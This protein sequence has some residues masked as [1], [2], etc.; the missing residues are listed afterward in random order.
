MNCFWVLFQMNFSIDCGYQKKLQ[1]TVDDNYFSIVWIKKTGKV[2]KTKDI[3]RKIEGKRKFREL[4]LQNNRPIKDLGLNR[5]KQWTHS[6][7][8]LS[9]AIKTVVIAFD[10]KLFSAH[11]WRKWNSSNASI[12]KS[13][14]WEL[15]SWKQVKKYFGLFFSSIFPWLILL[16]FFFV[17]ICWIK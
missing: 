8:S 12:F 13:G 17:T 3:K 7:N 1:M 2:C 5:V 4:T 9:W 16:F 14:S 10:R 15:V 6:D 11:G